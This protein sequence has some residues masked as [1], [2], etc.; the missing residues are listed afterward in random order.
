M[1]SSAK[2]LQAL[3]LARAYPDLPDGRARDRLRLAP[4]RPGPAGRRPVAARARPRA[5]GRPRVRARGRPASP[6]Q[7]QLLGQARRHARG[8]PRARLAHAGLPPRRP[9]APAGDP[10]RG[11]G[12][13]AARPHIAPRWTAAAS[14]PS[15][16]RSGRWRRAFAVLETLE[17]GDRVAAAMRARPELIRGETAADTMLM[18]ALPGWIAKGGAEGL[19]C[20]AGRRTGARAQGRG[21][22]R[23]GAPARRLPRSS[24][25]S[26]TAFRTG[27][28]RCQRRELPW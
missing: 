12:G 23:P 28:R 9:P 18:R 27:F 5:R 10:R 24:A 11:R 6:D 21:R 2:P 15:R 1:R 17:A 19:M 4:R 7:P 13:D 26:D 3:P 16:C 25:A 14:S 8:L 22:R 20:A